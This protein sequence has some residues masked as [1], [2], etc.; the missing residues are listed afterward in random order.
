MSNH[1]RRQLRE[2]IAAAVT[3]LTTTG[4]RV[5]QARV[6][7]LQNA[8]LPGLCVFTKSENAARQTTQIPALISRTVEILIEGVAKANA[9]LDDTLDLIAQ[10]VEAALGAGLTISGKF[11]PIVYGGMDVDLSG[12][13]EQPTG[14]ISMRFEA[15]LLSRAN[16]P[17]LFA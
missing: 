14:M 17:D 6:Y 15:K 7:P 10:E 13:G 2:A 16:T 1:I 4:A 12:E 9:D 5:F 8:D 3:G 11:V